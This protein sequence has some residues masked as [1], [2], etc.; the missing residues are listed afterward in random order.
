MLPRVLYSDLFNEDNTLDKK[1]LHYLKNVLR[2]TQGDEF[3]LF[4]GKG[5]EARAKIIFNSNGETKFEIDNWKSFDRENA[6]DIVVAQSICLSNKMDLVVQKSTELGANLILPII[7]KR[8][9]SK[10]TLRKQ[11]EKVERWGKIAVSASAQCGRNNVPNILAPMKLSDFFDFV[12]LKYSGATKW[13]LDPFCNN[14]I[15]TAKLKENSNLI[16]TIG[17]EAGFT[18]CEELLAHQNGFQRIRCGRRILR[19]ETVC[20]VALSVIISRLNQM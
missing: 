5:C 11:K 20:I 9:V 3:M 12:N 10:L 4:D 15:S 7:T 14:S 1:Q 13:I 6:I 16:L 17:P 18:D 8:T 2:L 19:T